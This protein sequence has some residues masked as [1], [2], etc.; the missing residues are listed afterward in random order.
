MNP[1]P[2]R[3]DHPA[4]ILIVDDERHNRQL[5]EVM[6]MPE[7]FHLLTAAGGEEAL[8]KRARIYQAGA[9]ASVWAY[10]RRRHAKP[11]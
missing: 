5:L 10:L 4:R 8:R 3:A 9:I 1:S 2:D 6:L 11:R 7:G